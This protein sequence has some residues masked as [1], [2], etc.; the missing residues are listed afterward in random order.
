M[1]LEQTLLL[2]KPNVVRKNKI[3]AVIS[4]LEDRGLLIKKMRMLIMT[5]ELAGKFYAVHTGKDFYNRL[6]EFMTSGPI[7]AIVLEHDNCVAYVREIIG[8]T[9]PEKAAEGTIR[10]LYAD[11]LTENAVHASDSPDNAKIEIGIIFGED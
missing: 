6:V 4:I 3:G 9:N 11:S 1:L 10:K 8:N 2:I 5:K 7:V